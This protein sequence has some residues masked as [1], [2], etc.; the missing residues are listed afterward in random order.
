A[1]PHPGPM[2]VPAPSAAPRSGSSCP[3]RLSNPLLS[4][5]ISEHARGRD[6][7]DVSRREAL[8]AMGA[9]ALAAPDA[10]KPPQAA[11]PAFWKSRLADV[12]AA[13]A[14]VKRGR[15]RVLVKSAGGR[16]VHL[17]AYGAA[18]DPKSA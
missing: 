17:V 18:Q 2:A 5:T 9:L 15:A 6:A 13:V 12:D 11:L 3:E 7:M 14:G 4:K 10:A 16:D 1:P 8:A